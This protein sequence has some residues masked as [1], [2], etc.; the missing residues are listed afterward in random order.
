MLVDARER[1]TNRGSRSPS[2]HLSLQSSSTSSFLNTNNTRSRLEHVLQ[3][4]QR[5]LGLARG[6]RLGAAGGGGGALGDGQR[7]EVEVL[8]V[9]ELAGRGALLVIVQRASL[10]A[11]LRLLARMLVL[12]HWFRIVRPRSAHVSE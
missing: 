2:L 7:V 11:T 8:R 1:Q 4:G 6:G 9:R 12:V 5:L 3:L 10:A